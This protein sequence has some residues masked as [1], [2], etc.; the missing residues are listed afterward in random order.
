VLPA[1]KSATPDQDRAPARNRI[2]VSTGI[3]VLLAVLVAIAV[4]IGV[5]PL[6][7]SAPTPGRTGAPAVTQQT[8]G[9][10]LLFGASAADRAAIE[11]TETALGRKLAGVRLFR[12]WGQP[13]IDADA[14]WAADGGRTLFI[15][16]RSRY[17][18]GQ[19][20]P[21]QQVAA[22][23]P[24]T[25]LYAAMVEQAREVMQFGRPVYLT[26]N[27]EPD[28]DPENGD[29]S[30][31]VAAWRHW[32]EVL[33]NQGATNARFV[34]TTTGYGY[35][36]SG[37]R[38]AQAYWPGGQWTD[39]IGVDAYNSFR[40]KNP[41][42]TWVSPAELLRPVMDFARQHPDR[43]VVLMEWSSVEDP[44]DPDRKANWFRELAQVL[45]QPE[46]DQVV[47]LLQ[48]GGDVDFANGGPGCDYGYSSSAAAS[49]AFRQV[50][51]TPALQALTLP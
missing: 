21:F 28:A 31:F 9:R 37:P 16:V 10:S 32:V 12:R 38:A 49:Q 34:W 43:A 15:S 33:R 8:G 42:G 41:T 46:Y 19:V 22:A 48:W 14:S 36:K 39:L 27:H 25:P 35:S 3:A 29:S 18:N 24:G 30:A 44:A 5:S 40:C 26:F 47:G 1:Q 45:Q 2:P 11:A 23:T 7:R 51:A 20:I 6:L 13:L 17:Q 4:G 50:A